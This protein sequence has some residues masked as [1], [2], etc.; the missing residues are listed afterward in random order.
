VEPRL[1]KNAKYN[2]PLISRNPRKIKGITKNEFL[3]SGKSLL[4]SAIFLSQGIPSKKTYPST[5][6]ALMS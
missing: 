5:D 3:L 6:P 1:R 2:E 4:G